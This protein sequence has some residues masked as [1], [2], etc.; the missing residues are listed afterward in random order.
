MNRRMDLSAK[1]FDLQI[2]GLPTQM[3]PVGQGDDLQLLFRF[4]PDARSRESGVAKRG[5]TELRSYGG[6]LIL[7]EKTDRPPV[8]H[9]LGQ[10]AAHLSYSGGGEQRHSLYASLRGEDG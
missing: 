4:Y 5:L 1:F 3:N 2:R 7:H 10:A 8:A 9:S 6:T